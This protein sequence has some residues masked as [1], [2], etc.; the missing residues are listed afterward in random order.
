MSDLLRNGMA[1]Q[2]EPSE[3]FCFGRVADAAPALA[4]VARLARAQQGACA[5]RG[6]RQA[7]LA[8]ASGLLAD[9][10]RVAVGTVDAVALIR[11]ASE[12]VRAAMTESR[13]PEPAAAR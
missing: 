13:P 9:E 6:L 2:A 11:D 5:E 10:R 1:E 7:G 4:A 12:R 3:D 8:R